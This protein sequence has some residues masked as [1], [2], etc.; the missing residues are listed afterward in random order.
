MN[1]LLLVLCT[2]ICVADSAYGYVIDTEACAGTE[3][4]YD[5]S[6]DLVVYDPTVH[7]YIDASTP[8]FY[9]GYSDISHILLA[10]SRRANIIVTNV[11]N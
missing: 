10:D 3:Y 1:K 7:T 8:V 9:A 2:L 5:N 6:G 4:I 11:S